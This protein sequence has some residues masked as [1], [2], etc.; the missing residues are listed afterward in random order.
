MLKIVHVIVLSEICVQIFTIII[1]INK[2]V[3]FIND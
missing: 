1:L 2:S 3:Y